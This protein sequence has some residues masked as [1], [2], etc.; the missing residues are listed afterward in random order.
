VLSTCAVQTGCVTA[1]LTKNVT[2]F[3]A[4]LGALAM[5]TAANL[6]FGECL[7]DDCNGRKSGLGT[8]LGFV[9]VVLDEKNPSH[10]AA[11][12]RLPESDKVAAN[13]NSSITDIQDY[14][15]S[16]AEVVEVNHEL[17]NT[18]RSLMENKNIKEEEEARAWG[19]Q[20]TSELQK[21]ISQKKLT[22]KS[23]NSFAE[24]K[25]VQLPTAVA[26]IYLQ[27][28]FGIQSEAGCK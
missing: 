23:L 9:A 1:A 20:N 16:L 27:T 5:G 11:T 21:I 12:N 7:D 26:K 14:N 25:K 8:L 13:L 4:G 24:S 22:C 18:V 6:S 10:I 3:Y 17:E 28:R 19:F 15:N 2:L